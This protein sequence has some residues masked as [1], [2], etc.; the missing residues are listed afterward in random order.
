MPRLTIEI[1]DTFN[2]VLDALAAGGSK[3]DVIR[4]AVA[5]YQYLKSEIPGP[6]FDRVLSVTDREGKIDHNIILP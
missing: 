4:K 5:T 3:G 1:D 2:A 6:A